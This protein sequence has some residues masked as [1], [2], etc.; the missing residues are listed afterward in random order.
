MLYSS[1]NPEMYI[2]KYQKHTKTNI[3][4]QKLSNIDNKSAY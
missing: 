1:K 2:K 4:S 3:N